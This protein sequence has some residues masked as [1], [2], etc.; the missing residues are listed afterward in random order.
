MKRTRFYFP[1]RLLNTK[2]TFVCRLGV[3]IGKLPSPP[4]HKLAKG[5]LTFLDDRVTWTSMNAMNVTRSAVDGQLRRSGR[6]AGAGGRCRAST[7]G[8]CAGRPVEEHGD[9]DL[10]ETG[11]RAGFVRGRVRRRSPSARIGLVANDFRREDTR[12]KD[13]PGGPESASARRTDNGIRRF[14]RGSRDGS[15]CTGKSTAVVGPRRVRVGRPDGN[16]D[17]WERPSAVG[18]RSAFERRARP[19]CTRRPTI[20]LVRC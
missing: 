7:D 15:V 6:M 10:R 9:D 1:S 2:K 12:T 16:V 14:D 20:R 19:V 8:V 11:T 3:G 18:V 13:V 17:R 5:A 4:P